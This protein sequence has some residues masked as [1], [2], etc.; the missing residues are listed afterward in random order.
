MQVDSRFLIVTLVLFCTACGETRHKSFEELYDE[1]R[2]LPAVYLTAET[3]ARIIAPGDKGVFVDEKSGELAW[4]AKTCINPDCP[5]ERSADEPFL[6]IA[7]DPAIIANPDGTIG[8]DR[9]R[10]EEADNNFGNCPECLKIREL[11][12]ESEKDRQQYSNWAI[13][14]VL[15]ETARRREELSEA[16]KA[17]EERLKQRIQSGKEK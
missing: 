10:V 1:E 13:S 17:R 2:A 9:S 11:R 5:A 3:N 7:P 15:P 4:P 8:Y 16:R 14:Y 12:K 6:F